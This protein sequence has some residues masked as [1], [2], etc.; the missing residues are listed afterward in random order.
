MDRNWFRTH[1][2]KQSQFTLVWVVLIKHFV[3]LFNRFPDII[4]S[5]T[6]NT[7]VYMQ[8]NF[9]SRSARRVLTHPFINMYIE[10]TKQSTKK[11]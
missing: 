2:N 7:I 1:Y 10:P 4:V 6:S 8:Y 11:F 3:Q 5:K 9:I